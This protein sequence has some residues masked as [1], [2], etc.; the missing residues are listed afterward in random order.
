MI[1]KLPKKSLMYLSSLVSFGVALMLVCIKIW[2]W[3][4]TGSIALLTSAADSLVD[5]LASMVTLVGVYYAQRP[6]D[7][8]HR[9]GHGKAEA[10]AAFVQAMLLAAAG[11]ALGIESVSRLM[12][13]QAIAVQGLLG[14][15]VI[16]TSIL[17]ASLLVTMQTLVVKYTQSTAI[18]AD[19]AHYITDIAMNIAVLCALILEH[20]FGW[21]RADASG[22]LAISC[23]M[24]CNACCMIRSV[25]LQLLDHELDSADRQRITASALSCQGVEGVHDLRTRNGGDRIFVELHVEVDGQLTVDAG[26][27]ICD[28][29]EA[30][31]KALFN[32]AEVSA[33]LEP[34][35]I[36]DERLDDLIK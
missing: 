9:F 17:C 5:V 28:N 27:A 29:A 1:T 33:H 4:E 35:G 34:A 7:R 21:I 16:V 26:H 36:A 10:I 25:M 6:A 12:A 32:A 8:G 13:P 18:A 30:A 3:L 11:V 15:I 2:A 19:R 24:V 31:V 14:I 22:A 20:Q 23:Y